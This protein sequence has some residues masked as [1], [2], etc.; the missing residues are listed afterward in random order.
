MEDRMTTP[1]APGDPAGE[2]LVWALTAAV[3]RDD[4]EACFLLEQEADEQTV[5]D[6]LAFAI[7]G[8]V[9][10]LVR[11]AIAE[12]PGADRDRDTDRTLTAI[13]DAASRCALEAA[14]AND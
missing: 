1:Q 14:A 12:T 7:S 8:T 6:A 3:A 4:R 2:R 13:A 11:A 10:A 5:R 9:G